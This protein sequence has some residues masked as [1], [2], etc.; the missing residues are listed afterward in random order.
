[1]RE[2][3]ILIFAADALF[4][5]RKSAK[6]GARAFAERLLKMAVAG[7]DFDGQCC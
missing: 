4:G 6:A 2:G 7:V 1:M 5:C 3:F